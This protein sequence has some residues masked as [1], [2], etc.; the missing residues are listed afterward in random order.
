MSRPS[1]KSPAIVITGASQGIGAATAKTLAHSQCRLALVARNEEKLK[2][3]QTELEDLGSK[4]AIFPYDLSDLDKAEQLI[5]EV[6]EHF[7]GVH[8]LINNAAA[9]KPLQ[10][11]SGMPTSEFIQHYNVN[12]FSP[13]ILI[14]HAIP[15]L[16]KNQG[17]IINIGTGASVHP[18][19]GW[20]AYCSSKAALLQYT[21]VV[22]LEN[23]QL[24]A[25]SFSPG[26]V[27]TSLQADIRQTGS[28]AM[29]PSVH[30][31]F[32]SL[33][34]GGLLAPEVPAM[35]IAWLALHA[36]SSFSGEQVNYDHPKVVESAKVY[37][38]TLSK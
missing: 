38:G 2:A 19:A 29:Q 15:H 16:I 31:Y 25:L 18:I 12:M 6:V 7:G 23:P 11:T 5:P 14:K 37:F 4:V 27:N 26:V 13:M 34:S 28:D 9:I 10:K 24:V 33:E 8:A 20:G 1:T 36:D 30:D 32:K 35:G 17:R 21:R 22:A 3:L